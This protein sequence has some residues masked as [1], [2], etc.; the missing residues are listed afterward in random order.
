MSCRNAWSN[1]LQAS[2][3][4]VRLDVPRSGQGHVPR[5]AWLRGGNGRWRW[6][7][8]ARSGIYTWMMRARPGYA[9]STDLHLGR[10][11]TC[12]IAVLDGHRR[13]FPAHP[14]RCTR[15]SPPGWPEWL[16]EPHGKDVACNVST[17]IRLW[18]HTGPGEGHFV[19][20]LQRR[21]T[22]ERVAQPRLWPPVRLPL[23]C[24]SRHIEHSAPPIGKRPCDR[25][26]GAGRLISLRVPPELPDLSGR[27]FLH[28]G[29]WLGT[30]KKD[31][32]EPSH[33]LALGLT[34]RDALHS[35]RLGVDS[36]DLSGI[37][38]GKRFRSPGDDGWLLSRSTAIPSVGGSG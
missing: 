6:S 1:G 23:S 4:A 31:R 11:R 29:W 25:T 8:A 37:P 26:P 30:I 33:A 10:R 36:P 28:P 7:T 38:A 2:S 15:C 9:L 17:T 32:F 18:P 24:S 27:R 20:V 13:R 35:V 14:A 5:R 16:A 22:I 21:P 34:L 19:A 3:T 12:A